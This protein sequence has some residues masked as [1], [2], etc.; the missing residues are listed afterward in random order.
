M[1]KSLCYENGNIRVGIPTNNQVDPYSAFAERVFF[2]IAKS[3]ET[4]TPVFMRKGRSNFL[5]RQSPPSTEPVDIVQVFESICESQN[6]QEWKV[7]FSELTCVDATEPYCDKKWESSKCTANQHG[8]LVLW[9]SDVISLLAV[10][11]VLVSG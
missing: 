4:A 7:R 3:L 1:S 6:V 2:L 5:T 9:N 10:V 8:S 11:K